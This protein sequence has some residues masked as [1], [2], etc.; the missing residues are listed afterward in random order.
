MARIRRFVHRFLSL[1]CASNADADL[2]R[3]IGAHL[4]LLRAIAASV[5]PT[6]R[7]HELLPLEKAG[8][9]MWL[10]MVFLFRL[11]VVM[12]SLALF[13][14]LTGI[15]SVMSFTVSRRTREIGIRVALG[16]DSRRIVATIFSRAFGQVVLG[17][18]S[19]GGLVF[20]LTR[21]ISGLSAKEAAIVGAYMLLMM[22]VCTLACIVPTRRALRIEPIEALREQ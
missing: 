9:T 22:G 12:S 10:E 11:F 18:I 2:A 15:Y 21:I 8:M 14:S 7:V 13:L 5:D 1:L 3:Q 17:I 16:A 20:A 19:G 6:L 4:Q